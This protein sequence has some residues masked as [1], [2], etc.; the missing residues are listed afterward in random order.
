MLHFSLEGLR[1]HRPTKL[2]IVHPYVAS[3][4]PPQ[5]LQSWQPDLPAGCSDVHQW[6]DSWGHEPPPDIPLQPVSLPGQQYLA[7][8]WKP[9]WVC[10]CA[11]SCSASTAV[12]SPT[13]HLPPPRS[14]DKDRALATF[15]I[16]LCLKASWMAFTSAN[17][18]DSPSPSAVS[19]TCV[20]LH[21]AAFHLR[22]FPTGEQG[23]LLL[24][25][26][27]FVIQW[28]FFSTCHLLLW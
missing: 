23:I 28:G 15:P 19:A 20:G 14:Q 7:T 16:Q 10:L 12:T 24:I 18:L 21:T 2:E 9:R 11:A 13:G 1:C 22:C 6:P 5:P 17:W 25:F 3:P 8:T 26:W 27:Q 4:D